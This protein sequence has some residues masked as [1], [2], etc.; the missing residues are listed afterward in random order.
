MQNPHNEK[1]PDVTGAILAGGTSSRMGR[2][3]ALL[4]LEGRS[5]FAGVRRVMHSLLEQV[6]IAGDRPDLADSRTPAF[7]D[8]HPGSALGGL[9]TALKASTSE[10][11]CV[12]PCDLPYPSPRLLR[13]LLAARA[14]VQAV[15]PRTSL[16]ME[17]LIACYRRDCLPILEE[18]LAR[19]SFRLTEFLQRLQVRTL[20]ASELPPG[21]RRALAN[22]NRHEDLDKTLSKPP[23]VTFIARSGTG[24]TTLLEKLIA[25]M[26]SRGW[27]IGALKHDA[28]KFEIDHE[29]K[30]SWRF[31]R[32]GAAV[33]S[34]SSPAKTAI[35]R[36][37]ELQPDL[38]ELLQPFAGKVDII[39]TEGFKKS[40]LPKIEAHRS[41]LGQPL[42]SRGE[43]H[44]PA[45]IAIVSDVSLDLDVPCLDL[46]DA[47]GL[48]DF[49][50]E[51]F[52]K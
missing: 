30:D 52:L 18:Q 10:W 24:K 22:L 2:D 36:Q 48:A 4:Q 33:T 21:W 14:D 9:H 32:A 8:L 44:D 26:T 39:L 31:T 17:P 51:R 23:V 15:V 7:A 11:I 45:L 12:L 13:T 38:D 49:I 25:E 37:H 35:I 16:G 6:L 3:K 46:N 20:D 1:Y 50:E 27:T 40:S 47:P 42:L 34:I 29:G 28:H 43:D 41:A 5:L 19:Q